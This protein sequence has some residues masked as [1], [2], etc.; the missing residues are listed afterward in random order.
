MTER[1]GVPQSPSPSHPSSTDRLRGSQAPFA[2]EEANKTNSLGGIM[3]KEI[4][5]ILL[6]AGC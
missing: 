3:L 6:W 4:L 1:L 5:G 2:H